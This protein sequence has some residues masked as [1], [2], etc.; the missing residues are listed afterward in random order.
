[1]NDGRNNGAPPGHAGQRAVDRSP[2]LIARSVQLF[3]WLI[4]ALVVSVLV[5]WVGMTFWWTEQGAGHSAA[6]LDTELGYLSGDLRRSLLVS[7]AADY[8]RRFADFAYR[9][10]WQRTGL[11]RAA[12]WAAETPPADA[13][14]LRKTVHEAYAFVAAYVASA[15]NITQV[16]AV[17]LAVLS[18]AMPA[19]LLAVLV[20]ALDGFVIRDLRKWCGGRESSYVY[21]HAK[22]WIW[23]VFVGAWVFY[24]SLPIS[25][26][27]GFSILPF[28]AVVGLLVAVTAGSFK[29]Y[30]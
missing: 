13:T 20:G 14:A 4:L 6:M 18:L 7:D 3:Y 15:A 11:E 8:A 16:F 28:A 2:G 10:L 25:V 1:M 29:K 24:L 27:P 5:E 22:R 30:L 17:R 9:W 26:H 21:H 19:F 23:P 12:V